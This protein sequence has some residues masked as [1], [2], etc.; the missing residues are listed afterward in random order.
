MSK[1]ESLGRWEQG[2]EWPL[3]LVALLFLGAYAWPILDLGLAGSLRS[4]C[5]V[6]DYAAWA[7]FI[8]D[9]AARLLLTPNRGRWFVRNLADLLVIALPVLRPLRLLR[10]VML[11][12][13]MNR[14][15]ADS[16][17]G[18][19]AVYV[20]A[21]TGLVLFCAALTVLDAERSRGGNI[22]SFGDALWWAIV[23]MATVGYGDKFPVTTEGR[24]VGVGLILAGIALLS[25]VTASVASWLIERVREVEFDEQAATRSDVAKLRAEL[26]EVRNLIEAQIDADRGTSR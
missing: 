17:H 18:R 5:R 19:V 21:S 7:A 15:A 8:V 9:Y 3:A 1:P 13:V 2:A 6:V 20:S 12:R 4:I 10:V 14:R 22:Q 11:L 24:F 26:K 16:L 25:I 23:T